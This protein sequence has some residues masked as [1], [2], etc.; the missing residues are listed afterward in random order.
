MGDH[1]VLLQCDGVVEVLADAVDDLLPDFDHLHGE[2]ETEVTLHQLG[3]QCVACLHALLDGGLLLDFGG[4]ARGVDLA[5]QPDRHGHLPAHEAQ[6]PILYLQKPV[7]AHD[8]RDQLLDL[9]DILRRHHAAAQHL[10]RDVLHGRLHVVEVDPDVFGHVGVGTRHVYPGHAQTDRCAALLLGRTFL[11]FG[12]L[13]RRVVR[14]RHGDRF[15]E[16]ER[17][18]RFLCRSLRQSEERCCRTEGLD[19]C[20]HVVLAIMRANIVDIRQIP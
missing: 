5:A 16:R 11:V 10:P 6:A 14:Q 12:R 9:R 19:C 1:A 2:R 17:P 15:V 4:P 18:G 3:H 8:R 7:G 13:H 20:F